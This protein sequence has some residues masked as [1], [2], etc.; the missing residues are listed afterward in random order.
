MRSFEV[1][2]SIV[3]RDVHRSGR[4]WS[5]QAL[6]V[7]DDT[8][9]ALITACAPGAQVRWPALYA[10]AR[11][12]DDRSV[13]TEAF[14]ALATGE[15]ELADA[16]WQETELVLWK[17]PE[18]WFSVNAF[19]IPDEERDGGRRL[20]NWYVNFERPTIRNPGGFDT[21]DLAVDLLVA[22]DLTSWHWKDEDEYAHLRRLGVITDTEHHAVNAAR[23]QALA[24]IAQQ[25]GV[26]ADAE[27]WAVWRW[28]PAWPAPTWV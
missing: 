4:V 18:T 1:G 5:E 14:D 10:R 19:Y 23:G 8:D 13:R 3:R 21:F 17:P 16:V 12:E 6:R 2:E 9:Q 28:D 26:F 15:W 11:A 27:R 25:T 22:P 24:M 7:I 20:R